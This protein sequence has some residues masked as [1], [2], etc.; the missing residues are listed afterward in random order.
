MPTS[1]WAKYIYHCS[2]STT[3]W[4]RPRSSRAAPTACCGSGCSVSSS[5]SRWSTPPGD[6]IDPFWGFDPQLFILFFLYQRFKN[7][8]SL[9]GIPRRR[10]RSDEWKCPPESRKSA[11]L[12]DRMWQELSLLQNPQ[13][14]YLSLPPP[15][16]RLYSIHHSVYCTQ[17]MY[18]LDC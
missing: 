17:S 11:Q 6:P 13:A 2:P 9:I 8:R 5:P 4:P 7:S 16:N 10:A 14:V 15:N 1:K 3:T 12:G 18:A